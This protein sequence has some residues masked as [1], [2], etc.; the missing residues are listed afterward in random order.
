MSMNL[1]FSDSILLINNQAGNGVGGVIRI[2][3]PEKEKEKNGH[4]NV[5]NI[6][7]F[8][9]LAISDKDFAPINNGQKLNENCFNFVKNFSCFFELINQNGFNFDPYFL[10]DYLIDKILIENQFD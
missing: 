1:K 9:L 2:V 3:R 5:V 7:K 10:I 6:E 4:S 8:D